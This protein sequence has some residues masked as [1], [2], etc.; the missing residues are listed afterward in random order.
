MKSPHEI[1]KVLFTVY[2]QTERRFS[3]LEVDKTS[4]KMVSRIYRE[5]LRPGNTVSG[6]SM[7]TLADCAMYALVLGVCEEQVQAVTTNVSID[8]FRKPIMNELIAHARILK[9]GSRL[10]F[11]TVLIKSDGVDVAHASLTYALDTP[12][13]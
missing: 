12:S 5:D 11:G 3:I 2:P 4:L 10:V 9:K 1:E 8:F 6:P 13:Q 7:F